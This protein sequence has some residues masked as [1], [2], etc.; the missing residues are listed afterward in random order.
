MDAASYEGS[1]AALSTGRKATS[2]ADSVEEALG[3][4]TSLDKGSPD[5]GPKVVP[6]TILTLLLPW[7]DICR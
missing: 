2:G 3:I 5:I 6:E 1:I 4:K 7:L